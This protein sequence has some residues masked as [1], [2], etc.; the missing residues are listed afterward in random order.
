MDIEIPIAIH[1]KPHHAAPMP[2]SS[3]AFRLPT[4]WASIDPGRVEGWIA[5]LRGQE[6]KFPGS[7]LSLFVG[8]SY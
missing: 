2:I 4:K 1:T 6:L 3:L 7:L 5:M 8:D